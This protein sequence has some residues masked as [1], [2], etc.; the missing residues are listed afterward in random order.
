MGQEHRETWP[1]L[2]RNFPIRAEVESRD[3]THIPKR[4]KHH[5]SPR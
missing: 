5:L 1:D 3:A 2:A 4:I